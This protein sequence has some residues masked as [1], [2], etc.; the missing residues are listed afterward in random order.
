MKTLNRLFFLLF[1]LTI[2][3]AVRGQSHSSCCVKPSTAEFAMLACD[4]A[5]LASHLPPLPFNY[6]SHGGHMIS[7]KTADGK[8]GSAFEVK[9]HNPTGNYLFVFQEWWGLNDYIKQTAEGLFHEFGNVTVLALDLYDGKIAVTADSAG[10][11]MGEAKEERIR[12][13]IKGAIDYAGPQ[14]N[15][16]TIGWCFGGAWSLQATMMA[17]K[18]AKGCVMYYGMPEKDVKKIKALNAPVLGLFAGK[19]QWITKEKVEQFEKDMKANNKEIAIQFFDADH[20]FANPSNPKHD[21]AATDEA[22]KLAV[23]FL[24]K[25]F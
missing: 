16:Q 25:H 7:F 1:A 8:D 15:I 14:A 6:V 10:K 19:D 18:Q 2:S 23:A 20:A 22:Y 11:L 5:F 24:R 3:V 4:E 9:G 21:Q 12:A 13:I 17:G